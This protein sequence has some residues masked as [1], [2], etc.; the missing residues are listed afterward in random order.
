MKGNEDVKRIIAFRRLERSNQPPVPRRRARTLSTPGRSVLA[1]AFIVS[2]L[3][4]IGAGSAF[5]SADAVDLDLYARLLEA[6]TEAVPDLVG[7]RVDYAGLRDSA[8]LKA[9]VSQ[10]SAA[11]PSQLDRDRRMAFWINAYNILAIDL[12]AKN[13]PVDS[14]KDIGSFFSPVWGHEV[15]RIEGKAISLETIEH[16][17]L[18]KMGDPRIH[19]A[20]VCASTSCPSLAR[21]PFRPDHL[22]AD[23]DS[24]MRNWLKSAQKGISIDRKRKRIKLSKIFDWFEEDFTTQGGVL[25]AIQPYL[26][27][28]RALWIRMNGKSASVGYLD[29]DWTLND[30]AKAR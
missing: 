3:S 20:I 11:R 26:G 5:G 13:Y 9:L 14:I 27:Q 30:L 17:I 22:D 16:G 2:A 12:V 25:E 18:R 28:S 10:V 21:V 7:T 8:D 15:A 6:H 29:Y 1:T 19:A 23:L 4:I 24:A